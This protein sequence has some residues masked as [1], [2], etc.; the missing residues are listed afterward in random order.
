[1]DDETDDQ[2]EHLNSSRQELRSQGLALGHQYRTQI[3]SEPGVVEDPD[4]V[5]ARGLHLTLLRYLDHT[6]ILA[7]LNQALHPSTG[8][9]AGRAKIQN[10]ALSSF[11][12]SNCN[13]SSDCFWCSWTRGKNKV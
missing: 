8:G 12:S 10:E 11:Y 9:A 13:Y 2:M 1:M 6:V 4:H 5:P 3:F 7:D